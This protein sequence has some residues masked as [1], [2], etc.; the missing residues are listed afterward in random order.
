MS[1]PRGVHSTPR[2][3]IRLAYDLEAMTAR[4]R[5]GRVR[6]YANGV[7]AASSSL[8][9]IGRDLDSIVRPTPK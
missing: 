7:R 9:N 3:R 2:S 1:T 4:V 5:R 6:Q 8:G